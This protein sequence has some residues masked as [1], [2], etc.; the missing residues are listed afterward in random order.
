MRR[1]AAANARN[2]RKSQMKVPLLDL[3]VQHEAIAE[4]IGVAVAGVLSGQHF[5][6]GPEVREIEDALAEYCG[7]DYGIGC[8]SGS[9]A[10]LLAMMAL[11]IGPGDEVITTPFSFFATAGCIARLGAKPVFVDIEPGT[12]N[13]DA[14]VLEQAITPR[15]RAILPVH[16]F[17]QC[18]AMDKINEM[19]AAHGIPVIEDAAQSIGADFGG[20]RAGSLGLMGA[21]SF[22]PSKN[23]GGAGDGGLITTSD[24]EI[25]GK[26][27]AMRAHGAKKKYFHDTVGINSRL[28]TLQAA[29]L[30]VKFRHL[31]EWTE[32]RRDNAERYRRSFNESGLVDAGHVTLP[33]DNGWGRHVYNQFVIRAERRD[34]LRQYLKERGVGSEVYY[35]LPLHLQDCFSYLGYRRGQLPAAELASE[36]ALA[37]PIYPELPVAAMD[38]VVESIGSFY[39]GQ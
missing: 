34:N 17:G 19:A 22:Y 10:L 26:L 15:T 39:A 14:G 9:D 30:L 13:I 11:D 23:L 25:A 31:E 12:F 32:A 3:K 8:A 18:A 6:L 28:D 16:L 27:R 21:F 7:A 37:I 35:P 38:Y 36:E 2:E 4:E 33:L 20:R 24:A 29:I 5:I 1:S